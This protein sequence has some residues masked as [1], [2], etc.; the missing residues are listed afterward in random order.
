MPSHGLTAL[1]LGADGKSFERGVPVG[2]ARH[3]QSACAWAQGLQPQQR[4]RAGLCGCRQRQPVGQL[5]LDGP[6][7]GSPVVADNHMYVF[8]E[9]GLAQVVDLTA[10][11]GNVVGKMD[12][13]EMIQCSPAVS[14]G[15]L[16][17]RSNGHIWKIS[18]KTCL[19]LGQA[20]G[21]R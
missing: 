17:V 5:R 2:C 9:E 10:P 6:F 15:A 3:G 12:L 11:E 20:L 13:G 1:K 21:C 14:N 18:N 19:K 4:R 8:S 16:F 7:G